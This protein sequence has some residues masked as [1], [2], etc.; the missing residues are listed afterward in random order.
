MK[1]VPQAIDTSQSDFP[2]RMAAT[3]TR[4]RE[5]VLLAGL[6]GDPMGHALEAAAMLVGTFPDLVQELRGL[7]KPPSSIDLARALAPA[8]KGLGRTI[9]RATVAAYAVATVLLLAVG[10]GG[11]W[12][13]RGYASTAVVVATGQPCSPAGGGWSACQFIAYVK[14]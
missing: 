14:Q 5:A 8:V 11:G 13:M 12:V 4:I 10:A 3:E 1:I 9:N 2:E 6:R 7:S